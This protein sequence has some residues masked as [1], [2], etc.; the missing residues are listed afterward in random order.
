MGSAGSRGT[1]DR[2]L[3]SS[4]NEGMH[5]VE[6]Q[7]H[8]VPYATVEVDAI[9]APDPVREADVLVD[10]FMATTYDDTVATAASGA[11]DTEQDCNERRARRNS[12]VSN[13]AGEI[14]ASAEDEER[15]AR[16]RRERHRFRSQAPR[17]K[18]LKEEDVEI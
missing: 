15:Y 8:E 6:P 12:I 5:F 9:R 10:S 4:F 14:I 3:I 18:N 13:A 16:L 7:I 17:F 2:D 1:R 11:S